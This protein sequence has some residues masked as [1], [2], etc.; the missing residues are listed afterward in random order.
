MEYPKNLIFGAKINQDVLSPNIDKRV[1][2]ILVYG[3]EYGKELPHLSHDSVRRLPTI[4]PNQIPIA[5]YRIS[6]AFSSI[7]LISK[8][9]S[10]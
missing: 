7:I 4:G 10:T 6:G 1:G 2:G 9:W 3:R 5:S 8:S